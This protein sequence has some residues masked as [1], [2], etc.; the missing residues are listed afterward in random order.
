[1]KEK[2][3]HFVWNFQLLHFQNL[4][5]VE[6]NSIEILHRGTWNQSNSGPDF[7]NAKIKIGHT[8]WAGNVEIHV[9][10][11]DWDLHHHS[12]DS[13]YSNV[14]LH[15]VYEADKEIDFLKQKKIQTLE[16]KSFIPAK[17]IENYTYLIA[18]K[19]KF[20]PCENLISQLDQ[21][22]VSIWLHHLLLQRL[23]NKV[24]QMET[25]FLKNQKSWEKLLFKQM[26]YTFGLKIN[27][28]AFEIWANSFDFKVLQKV[29]NRKNSVH[30]LFLGQAGFLDENFSEEYLVQLKIEYEF[31]RTKFQLE[32][33]SSSIFQFFRLRPPNFPTIRIAQL[34]EIYA[35]MS[36]LFSILMSTKSVERLEILFHELQL[37]QFWDNHYTLHKTSSKIFPKQI[38]QELIHRVIINVLIPLKLAYAKSIGKD[39]LDE[40]IENL[41][42]LPA[43]KN[44]I[45]EGFSDLGFVAKNAFD[46]Q[47]LVEL[48]L[49]FCEP[50]NCLN[51]NF[52]LQI[53]KH[54]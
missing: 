54:V 8:T 16:L 50:K 5:T 28:Q 36:N 21:Q 47:A 40:V 19:Q 33:I 44:T 7:S 25:L 22:N 42:V 30:A 23:A 15:V 27:A 35:Q 32:P 4:R 9:K 11:S 6:G 53:L 24:Q 17:V 26:A 38:S 46:S 2:F 41:Y 49:N 18:N 39:V 45:T 14:I 20:I 48:K 52:G 34:A 10:S 3:L 31:L 37:P 29:Q 51:C 12:T 1:M 13:A 43:E